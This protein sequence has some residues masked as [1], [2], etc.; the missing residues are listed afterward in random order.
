MPISAPKPCSYPGCNVLVRGQSRCALHAKKDRLEFEKRRGSAA[1]RGYDRHWKK[2]RDKFLSEEENC[3]CVGPD[4]LG[5]GVL[6]TVV[7]HIIP[8]KNDRRLFWD[9]RNWQP[10]C[11]SCHDK[12]TAREDGGFGRRK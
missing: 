11:K 12:K 6:A 9:K 3:Y 4:H 7:D 10:L 1:S 5:K 8:H 2:A